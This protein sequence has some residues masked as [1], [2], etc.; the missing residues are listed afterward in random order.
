MNQRR[1][2]ILPLMTLILVLALTNIGCQRFTSGTYESSSYTDSGVNNQGSQGNNGNNGGNNTT[3]SPTPGTIPSVTPSPTATPITPPSNALADKVQNLFMARCT[4]C[5][6]S[7]LPSG[8]ISNLT[9]A[10]AIIQQGL[11]VPGNAAGSV[12]YQSVQANRMPLGNALDEASKKDIAD[13]INQGAKEFTSNLPNNPP[14]N[15]GQTATPTP[16]PT[17]APVVT[18]LSSDLELAYQ[19]LQ[20]TA[21]RNRSSIRYLLVTHVYK[22]SKIIENQKGLFAAGVSKVLNSLHWQVA[23]NNPSLLGEAGTVVKIDLR[24]YDLTAA[25]WNRITTGYPYTNQLSRLNRWANLQ[26]LSGASIPVVRADWFIQQVTQPVLYKELLEIPD[27]IVDLE[28]RIGVNSA[29]NIRTANVLRAGLEDSGVSH[30]NR[31]IERHQSSFGAYWKSYDFANS[32][33]TKDIFRNPLG[34]LNSGIANIGQI[35]FVHDGGEMIFTLPNGMHGYVLTT[36]AGA[37][38][39]TGPLE[40]VE[41]PTRLDRLVTNSNSCFTCHTAGWIPIKD[42]IGPAANGVVSVFN[43]NQLGAINRRYPAAARLADTFTKDIAAYT[44]ALT[45][46]NIS[47]N[48]AEPISTAS[49][50]YARELKLEDIA[51]ELD[52]TAAQFTQLLNQSTTLRGQFEYSN[53]QISSVKITRAR[54]ET[55]FNTI[56]QEVARLRN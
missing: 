34:P 3:P 7:N 36:A 2:Q 37:Y 50:Y 56:N 25:E 48:N 51:A 41:D 47:V 21:S 17:P 33:G 45:K 52:M 32:N 19:D 24:Q 49:L 22:S 16:A 6:N 10:A 4:N 11:V 20:N 13:W 18:T 35:E 43:A 29:N 26:T 55:R 27:N 14:P 53:N 46:M 42:E 15:P 54:F 40:I 31:V 5:H 38:I 8:G 28:T 12:L 30:S 1:F 39:P 44:A 23:I 9:V